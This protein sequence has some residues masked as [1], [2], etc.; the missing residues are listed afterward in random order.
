MKEFY[1][2]DIDGY[3]NADNNMSIKPNAAMYHEFCKKY[4]INIKPIAYVGDRK[5]LDGGMA[6]NV[7]LKFILVD[8]AQSTIDMKKFTEELSAIEEQRYATRKRWQVLKNAT[9][10]TEPRPPGHRFKFD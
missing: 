2:V 7:N 10:L 1:G 4:D 8:S 6:S 9:W 3:I 5:D